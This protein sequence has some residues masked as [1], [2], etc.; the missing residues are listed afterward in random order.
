MET[1]VFGLDRRETD[2]KAPALLGVCLALALVCSYVE[3]LIP[4]S[5]G[6]PG[7]KLGLTNIVVVVMLYYIGPREALTVSVLRILLSGFLFGNLFG[8]LYGLAGGLLSFFCMCL[9]KKCRQIG[10]VSVSAAGG[11]MHNLGQT[12]VAALVVENIHLF[13]YFP[14]LMI[15]G[16]VTGALIGIA[17]RGILLRLPPR[18]NGRDRKKR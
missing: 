8:V 3:S 1:E 4:F 15:A 5:F 10:I 6:I 14:F 7:A 2:Q 12:A 17:A 13:Y 9:L 18:K 16:I 11:V